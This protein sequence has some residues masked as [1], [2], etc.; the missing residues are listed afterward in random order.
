MSAGRENDE[1]LLRLASHEIGE[2]SPEELFS[3]SIDGF[4]GP[5]HLLLELARRQKVDLLHVSIL[6]LAEQYLAFI[7]EAKTRRIDLAAD[8]LLMASWLAYL[9]SRLLL[10]APEK[11]RNDNE[12]DGDAMARRLAFRLAR[13]EALRSSMKDL[14]RGDVTGRD[15]FLRGLPEKARVIR[16]PRCSASLYD[17]IT[18]FADIQGRRAVRR[19]HIV[20][21]QPVL[22]LENARKSL[23]KMAED[24]KEW[25]SIRSFD[26]PEGEAVDTPGRSVTAS[27]FTAALELAREHAVDL[28]QD[29]PQSDV[30]VR[31]AATPRE[32]LRRVK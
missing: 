20:R 12:A 1:Q 13:L 16:Q 19:S 21:R 9:K 25:R 7:L 3:V 27:Y 22:S 32:E 5:L 28:R 14:R 15:V 26:L 18:S 31:G 11:R 24:L 17:L 4:E 10:P 2:V 6:Q 8:Y 29:S 23:R 30:L